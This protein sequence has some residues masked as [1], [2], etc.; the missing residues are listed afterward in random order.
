M[1]LAG[2]QFLGDRRRRLRV[3]AIELADMRPTVP[4]HAVHAHTHEEAHL[5]V[6][7]RGAYRSSARGMPEVCHEPV[8]I[9]NPPGTHHRDCF[10]SLQDARFLTIS[11][12]PAA[13]RAIDDALPLPTHARRLSALALPAAYRAWRALLAADDA[14]PLDVE[15]EVHAL[16]QRAAG[17]HDRPCAEAGAAWLVRA[18]QRLDDAPGEV[19]GI[20]ELAREAGLHPVYF[21]RAFR[22]ACGLAPGEYLRRR[23]LELA[24][25][26]LCAGAASLAE[27]ALRCGYAD[28]SHMAN[29]VRAAAGAS[30]RAL[31]ALAAL[32]VADLQDRR[33][34]RGQAAG[35]PAPERPA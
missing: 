15:A 35:I 13:W 24:V 12:A 14:A 31:R 28:Q 34:R 20:A 33:P 21:A 25:G 16:L 18:R 27:L 5:L 11:L 10:E 9:L 8:V 1:R 4:R 32:Q 6:L 29:A 23:R 7:H 26:G 22:R 19:P 17:D 30:P 2:G 3:E